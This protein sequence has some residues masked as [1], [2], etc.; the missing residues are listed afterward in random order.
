MINI[1]FLNSRKNVQ[2]EASTIREAVK[3]LYAQSFDFDGA[4]LKD[5]DLSE[6]NLPGIRL[7]R[8]DLTGVNFCRANLEGADLDCAW[9]KNS[10]FYYC[11]LKRAVFDA[12]YIAL[13][14]F[15]FAVLD[16]ASFID[17]RIYGV[18]F[19]DSNANFSNVIWG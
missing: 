4:I 7:S 14:N 3:I 18:S 13:S 15:A 8:T 1:R 6:L 5:A 12:S 10:N 17:A 2:V 11:N 16:D 9:I 19:P